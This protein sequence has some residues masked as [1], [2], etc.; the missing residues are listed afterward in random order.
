MNNKMHAFLDKDEHKIP[1]EII[2]FLKNSDVQ[3][4]ALHYII[5]LYTFVT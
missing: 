1:M 5:I 2:S 3:H 4:N